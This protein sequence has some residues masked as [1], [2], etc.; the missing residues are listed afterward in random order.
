MLSPP[1]R[2]GG[3][4]YYKAFVA[5]GDRLS[6][7]GRRYPVR[8]ARMDSLLE[9]ARG[10]IRFVKIDVEGHELPVVRG[11]LE[12]IS[13]WKPALLI[14]VSRDPDNPASSGFEL[15]RVLHLLGYEAH[16]LGPAGLVRRE[17]GDR[18]V[19]YFFL[20]PAHLERLM[21]TPAPGGPPARPL[22]DAPQ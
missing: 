9:R 5:E 1:Y 18:S 7:P 4:N 15:F 13:R 6:G 14:E 21:G 17:K 22:T 16:R 2:R 8:L 11:G 19:N 3:S 12:A 10:P 20:A